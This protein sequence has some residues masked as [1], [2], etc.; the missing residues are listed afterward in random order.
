MPSALVQARNQVKALYK[1]VTSTSI[2]SNSHLQRMAEKLMEDPAIT[3]KKHNAILAAIKCEER[4][5]LT[6]ARQSFE[7]DSEESVYSIASEMKRRIDALDKRSLQDLL[8]T[9]PENSLVFSLL[10]SGMDTKQ[11]S[12]VNKFMGDFLPLGEDLQVEKIQATSFISLSNQDFSFAQP[13][14]DAYFINL[15][16]SGQPTGIL[17][18]LERTFAKGESGASILPTVVSVS[19]SEGKY[20]MKCV[21]VVINLEG[22]SVRRAEGGAIRHLERM[23]RDIGGDMD[24]VKEKVANI[25]GV[26][27]SK[28]PQ[29]AFVFSLLSSTNPLAPFTTAGRVN[30]RQP[31]GSPAYLKITLPSGTVGIELPD[32]KLS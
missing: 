21:A 19:Y 10:S 16:S 25:F 31:T 4:A 28:A 7:T 11:V 9:Q 2:G 32:A 8:K 26:N 18:F 1:Q 30:F 3:Q 5:L 15:S 12:Q 17:A 23:F 14:A 29:E 13:A 24:L 27:I 20:T 22:R 6:L